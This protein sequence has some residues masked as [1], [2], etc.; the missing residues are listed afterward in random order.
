MGTN[1]NELW[2]DPSFISDAQK[3]CIDFEV[4]LVGKIIEAR[5]NRGLSQQEL[6]DLCG[7]KQPAIARLE[8][9]ASS[10]QLDTMLKILHPLGYRLDI[11]PCE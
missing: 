4:K 9:M 3:D 1:F 11:V 5:K 10:P 7:M 8:K 2:N 6:A